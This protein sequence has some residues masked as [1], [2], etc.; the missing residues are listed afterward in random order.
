MTAR[1]KTDTETDTE[2]AQ[3]GPVEEQPRTGGSFV[4]DPES[5]KLTRVEHPPGDDEEAP[6]DAAQGEV[7]EGEPAPARAEQ[8]QD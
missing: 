2:T 5:G 8:Q 3:G 4:R 7:A 1:K 6:A